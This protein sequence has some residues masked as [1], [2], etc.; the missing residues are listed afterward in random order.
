MLLVSPKGRL[1]ELGGQLRRRVVERRVAPPRQ[2]AV[3]L[4]VLAVALL[5]VPHV[6]QLPAASAAR[7]AEAADLLA[8]I[9]LELDAFG[10]ASAVIKALPGYD[11]QLTGTVIELG[12]AF[13]AA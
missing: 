11:D 5:L 4:G 7:V 13:G 3:G 6:V 12:Q 8:S 9:G 2:R 1:P 10:G